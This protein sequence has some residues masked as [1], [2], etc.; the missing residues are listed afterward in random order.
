MNAFQ[1]LMNDI[2]KN[3]DFLQ[4]CFIDN[5]A[6]DCIVSPITD[7]VSFTDAGLQSEQ[8]FTL[9]LKKQMRSMPKI[10]CQVRFRDRFYKIS[11]IETDSA[12][13]SIKIHLV[14]LSKGIG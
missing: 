9:D 13:Q 12:N 7:N 6:Y 10:N 11:D 1:R 4:K 14:A 3:K 8:N 2:F 5:I